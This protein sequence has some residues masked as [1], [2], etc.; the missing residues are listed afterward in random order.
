[1]WRRRSNP[2][3]APL[4]ICGQLLTVFPGVEISVQPGVHVLAI[5]PENR[6]GAHVTDLLAKLDLGVDSRG[7]QD[8]LVTR[9]GIEMVVSQIRLVGALPVLAHIDDYN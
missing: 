7:E 4:P 3:C 6:R 8:T 1:M 5:F 2:V 9:Y